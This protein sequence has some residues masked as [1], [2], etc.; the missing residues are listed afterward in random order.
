METD[1]VRRPTH[2]RGK[3]CLTNS[4]SNM[5]RQQHR[6]VEM[7]CAP[8]RLSPSVLIHFR[9]KQHFGP[10]A[11]ML[12][13]VSRIA[14]KK[15]LS[16][17]L[18]ATPSQGRLSQSLLSLG[19]ATSSTRLGL[20]FPHNETFATSSQRH[21]AMGSNASTAANFPKGKTEDQWQ[22]QLSPEQVRVV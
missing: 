5:W 11:F 16:I 22:A 7:S 9:Y 4:L 19:A 8:K 14:L 3:N 10:S 1:S 20:P 2:A 6:S 18:L 17:A 15:S 21:F 13:P 12:L